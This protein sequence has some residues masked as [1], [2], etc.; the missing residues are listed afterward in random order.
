[1]PWELLGSGELWVVLG[2]SWVVE[3]SRNGCES[4]GLG[5]CI[6][7]LLGDVCRVVIFGGKDRKAPIPLRRWKPTVVS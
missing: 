5:A 3:S 7:T 2:A 6:G 1:M 4:A